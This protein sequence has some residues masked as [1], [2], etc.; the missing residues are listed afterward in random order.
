MQFGNTNLKFSWVLLLGT[1]VFT[2]LFAQLGFW[3]LDRADEKDLIQKDIEQSFAAEPASLSSIIGESWK[4]LRYRKIEATGHF[5]DSFQIYLDN[6]IYNGKAGYHI[7]TPFYLEGS[8]A[9]ILV[10]RGWVFVGRDRKV[11][12]EVSLPTGMISL[13]GRLSSPRSKP[14]IFGD[15][16]MPDAYSEKLWTYLDIDYV[17]KKY[18][19]KLEP[20]MI[21]QEND[22]EDGLLRQLPDYESNVT[23]HLG[24]AVQWFAF[25]LFLALA[26]IRNGITMTKFD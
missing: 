25:A 26:F 15:D 5:D 14:T 21:L 16:E 8:D 9:A 3:Q 19:I 2:I 24:Y 17:S 1:I 18:Q 23:M 10:N 7:V 20:F 13:K 4:D 6:R 22:I 11:L 12:P